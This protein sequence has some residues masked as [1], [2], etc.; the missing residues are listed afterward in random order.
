MY[1]TPPS[2][3]SLHQKTNPQQCFSSK[4]TTTGNMFSNV[5]LRKPDSVAGYPRAQACPMFD[6][7]ALGTQK[8][9]KQ[10]LYD[11]INGPYAEAMVSSCMKLMGLDDSPKLKDECIARIQGTTDEQMEQLFT[12]YKKQCNKIARFQHN[13]VEIGKKRGIKTGAAV[14]LRRDNMALQNVMGNNSMILDSLPAT[15][16]ASEITDT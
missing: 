10:Q 12:D 11:A 1:H 13:S 9:K 4:C 3:S 15:Q 5:S 8:Q 16:R 14:F 7:S 6:N 2:P